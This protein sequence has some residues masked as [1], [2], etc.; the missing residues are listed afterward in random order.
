M[1]GIICRG[2]IFFIDWLLERLFI[3]ILGLMIDSVLENC[4]VLK[5]I[6]VV[7][8][9]VNMLV[10]LVIVVLLENVWFKFDVECLVIWKLVV[11]ICFVIRVEMVIVREDLYNIFDFLGFFVWLKNKSNIGSM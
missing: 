7:G 9:C 6:M 8:F 11:L 5:S 4:V 2:V 1:V 10:L 3:L